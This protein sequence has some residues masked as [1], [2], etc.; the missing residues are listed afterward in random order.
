MLIVLS[1]IVFALFYQYISLSAIQSSAVKVLAYVEEN[2]IRGILMFIVFYFFVCALPMPFVSVPT[3]LA[4]YLFGNIS[5]LLITSFV[6]VLGGGCLFLVT[7]Y[8]LRGV[9]TRWL[10]RRRQVQGGVVQ[11]SRLEQ[12]AETDSFSM[13]LGLRLIPGM[14]FSIPAI[15]LGLSR[16]SFGKF[17]LST[18]L[19]LLIT[20]FLY[21]NAGRSLAYIHSVADI[22][23]IQ[24]IISMLLL[25]VVPLLFNFMLNRFQVRS[26]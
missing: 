4:G 6:S 15:A 14:P 17:Y 5:G 1:V 26:T 22:L 7:R 3:M 23:N 8:L 24:I 16:L 9:L 18:Q 10:N 20:L 19:G 25:A 2:R 21:V 11:S 13:A 12:A